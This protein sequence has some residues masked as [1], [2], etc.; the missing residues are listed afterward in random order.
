MQVE[1][2]QMVNKTAQT[3]HPITPLIS[4]RWSPRA[5][6]DE[7]PPRDVLLRL[8]EAARWA[9]SAGNGQP[10]RFVVAEKSN[11]FAYERMFHVLFERNQ[12][13]AGSAPVLVLCA[14]SAARS[15]GSP[16]PW[17]FYDLGQAAAQL[18]LQAAELG[19]QA[20]PMAGF[21][22]ALAVSQFKLPAGYEPATILAI[23]YPGDP[24]ILP[25]DLRE[26]ELAQRSR[27]PL[28]EFVF[29]GEWG[30]PLV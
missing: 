4:Q 12:R 16:N 5:F 11:L 7:I 10:W 25:E 27:K 29:G 24:E 23:G 26:R 2:T 18:A 1:I 20:H 21:D 28:A 13:W 22:H 9:P 6:R 15:D 8:F 30:K 19:L 17:M 3:D 14:A